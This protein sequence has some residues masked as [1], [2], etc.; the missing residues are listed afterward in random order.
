MNGDKASFLNPVSLQHN[1][2]CVLYLLT[3][4]LM[5]ITVLSSA[6]IFVFLVIVSYLFTQ[7]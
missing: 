4:C 1:S 5:C 2:T 6:F 3:Y 7:T